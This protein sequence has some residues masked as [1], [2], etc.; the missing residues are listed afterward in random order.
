MSWIK[1]EAAK[2]SPKKE[3]IFFYQIDDMS[4]A[5]TGIR[6]NKRFISS[7]SQFEYFG[8]THYQ[9]IPKKL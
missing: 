5:F 3:Y 8:I 1:I 2:L 9:E 6:K 4:G 7:E